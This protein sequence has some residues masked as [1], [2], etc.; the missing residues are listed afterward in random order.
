M[1]P[2][3][4]A[5]PCMPRVTKFAYIPNMGVALLS[6]IISNARTKAKEISCS[7]LLPCRYYH[8][9]RVASNVMNA[10]VD[11]SSFINAPHEYFDPTGSN[12]DD[13]NSSRS[14]LLRHSHGNNDLSYPVKQS[15]CIRAKPFLWL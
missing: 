12:F 1:Y 4:S 8:D 15:F 10:S 7:S 11:Y 2:Y 5:M 13:Y 3:C 14:L 6:C 9:L